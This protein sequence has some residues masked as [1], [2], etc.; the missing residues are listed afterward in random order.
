MNAKHWIRTQAAVG[1]ERVTNGRYKGVLPQINRER[2][3]ILDRP[4]D[5][6]DYSV[7]VRDALEASGYEYQ[8]FAAVKEYGDL[9]RDSGS[10]AKRPHEFPEWLPEDNT[11]RDW[12]PRQTQ[13]HVHL[14]RD[15]D[16]T[17]VFGHYELA[18]HPWPIAGESVSV[19]F[20]RLAGHYHPVNENGHNDATASYWF[21]HVDTVLI[22]R[23]WRLKE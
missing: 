2:V 23:L 20:E 14:F 1:L 7:G 5:N 3:A 4:I 16:E 9:G 6:T 21:G 19:M 22:D 15:G 13:F 18:A 12:H 10:Y 17:L 11:L 8:P